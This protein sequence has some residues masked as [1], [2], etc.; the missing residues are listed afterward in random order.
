LYDLWSFADTSEDLWSL[1]GTSGDLWNLVDTSK[2]LR[3]LQKLTKIS[4]GLQKAF[5]NYMN[6]KNLAKASKMPT[7]LQTTKFLSPLAS[8]FLKSFKTLQQT[9]N[10]V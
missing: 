9:L 1:A 6:L 2:D 10:V 3:F 5:K 4:K 8:K 7:F